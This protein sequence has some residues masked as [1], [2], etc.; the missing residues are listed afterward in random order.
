MIGLIDPGRELSEGER[1]RVASYDRI[2]GR[3]GRPTDRRGS[4]HGK[5]VGHIGSILIRRVRSVSE[6]FHSL[7]AASTWSLNRRRTLF[8]YTECSVVSAVA[9]VP[10]LVVA[11][12]PLS[13]VSLKRKGGQDESLSSVL[14]FSLS[15]RKE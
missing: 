10:F 14:G 15:S 4:T 2:E 3:G 1:G 5:G 8:L 7:V 6:P 13:S 9:V 11:S 12:Y